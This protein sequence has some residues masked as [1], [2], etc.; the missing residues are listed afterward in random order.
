M[1]KPF[2]LPLQVGIDICHT[3]RIIKS[4]NGALLKAS[5]ADIGSQTSTSTTHETKFPHRKFALPDSSNKPRSDSKSIIASRHRLLLRIFNYHERRYYF[6][7]DSNKSWLNDSSQRKFYDFIAGRFAA[8]E[9]IIKAMRHRKLNFHDIIVLPEGIEFPSLRNFV[10]VSDLVDRS[11]APRAVV[12]A[13]QSDVINSNGIVCRDIFRFRSPEEIK[14][15]SKEAFEAEV[16]LEEYEEDL[17]RWEQGEEVQLNISH[18]GDYA[19][20]VCLAN[21]PVKS[22]SCQ[23]I[24]NIGKDETSISL[25]L[26]CR[27]SEIHSPRQERSSSSGIHNIQTKPQ[28]K[29]NFQEEK[30]ECNKD[31]TISTN[32]E[33]F[34][35]LSDHSKKEQKYDDTRDIGASKTRKFHVIETFWPFK[36]IYLKKIQRS[37]ASLMISNQYFSV[38]KCVFEDGSKATEDKKFDTQVTQAQ[39]HNGT[40]ED[41]SAQN[42]SVSSLS[43]PVTGKNISVETLTHYS[44]DSGSK[45]EKL[46]RDLLPEY[47]HVQE[48]K[49]EM[50][51]VSISN[52]RSNRM[53]FKMEDNKVF[54]PKLKSADSRR[55][56]IQREKNSLDH[57]HGDFKSLNNVKE[58]YNSPTLGFHK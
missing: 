2:S 44:D 46:L 1:P 25:K 16:L 5:S 20:A 31:A 45:P 11:R 43:I 40:T 17:R 35:A 12:L 6:K 39:Q 15:L 7:S 10:E 41:K 21:S 54:M 53:Q 27:Q 19:I 22:T 55:K 52:K 23:K 51:N 30:L 18:D 24:M 3:P 37:I 50:E 4:L 14:L 47:F 13:E 48:S 26:D 38:F 8:K 56:S 58:K 29:E 32:L 33:T 36:Y 28:S 42:P 9:A 34:T 49:C 57:R